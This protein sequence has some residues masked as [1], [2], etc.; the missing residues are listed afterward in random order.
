MQWYN[1]WYPL[2]SFPIWNMNRRGLSTAHTG[3]ECDCVSLYGGVFFHSKP[4]HATWVLWLINQC[5]DTKPWF[6]SSV[7]LSSLPFK[8][9]NAV[10]SL[11]HSHSLGLSRFCFPPASPLNVILNFPRLSITQTFIITPHLPPLLF[12]ALHFTWYYTYGNRSG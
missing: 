11:Y 4:L 9:A 6:C 12:I 1:R 3:L 7:R 5:S 2:S 10:S 8:A